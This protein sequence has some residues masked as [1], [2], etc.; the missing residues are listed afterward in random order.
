LKRFYMV[1]FMFNFNQFG[2][3]NPNARNR[4]FDR[5]SGDGGGGFRGNGGGRRNGGGF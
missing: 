5:N 2:G 3:K 4:T 1:S